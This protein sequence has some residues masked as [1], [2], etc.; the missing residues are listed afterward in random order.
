MIIRPDDYSAN[1]GFTQKIQDCIPSN[2]KTLIRFEQ[3]HGSAVKKVYDLQDI[4]QEGFPLKNVD[5]VF[6]MNTIPDFALFI[7]VADCVPVLALY[8]GELVCGFHAGW[9]GIA[10]GITDTVIE[11]ALERKMDITKLSFI[12][13]PHICGS[14]Y[15]VSDDVAGCFPVDAVSNKRLNLLKA[16]VV[17]LSAR[18][19][20]PE[21]I[22]LAKESG[23]CTFEN[24][25]YFSHR[26]QDASRMLLFAFRS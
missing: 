21:N 24:A 17:M 11:A 6:F 19:I 23:Y 8:D 9:R 18:G 13:G 22:I 4:P 2:V 12:A 26:R 20:R 25:G 7:K 1:E 5:G 15:E 10:S 3:V 14:C 16:L